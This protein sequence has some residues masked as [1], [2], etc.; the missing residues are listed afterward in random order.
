MK[1]N[2]TNRQNSKLKRFEEKKYI[3]SERRK[4]DTMYWSFFILPVAWYVICDRH[5]IF[6]I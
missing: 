5:L 4:S 3:N 2:L 1:K 6:K